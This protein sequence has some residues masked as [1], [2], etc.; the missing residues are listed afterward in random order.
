[1]RPSHYV[2]SRLN[3]CAIGLAIG[4]FFS[5]M[6]SSFAYEDPLLRPQANPNATTT[7]KA[8][9]IFKDMG[10]GMWRNGKGFG[11]VGALFAGLE[12]AI[13]SVRSHPSVC[14]S[15]PDDIQ[16]RAKNDMVNPVAA[17]FIAGGVLARNSGPRAVLGGAA[18]FAAFSAA[19][20][21]FLRRE[22]SECVLSTFGITYRTH[23]LPSVMTIR[24]FGLIYCIHIQH[25]SHGT[26]LMLNNLQ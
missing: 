7:Q 15:L 16:Y 13:E 25:S 3:F 8:R 21:M 26:S 22:L 11:K 17:G 10:K 6:S 23:V 1:M 4:A 2:V 9:E 18:A 5:L 20:D 19:I 24:A 14:R 12:C